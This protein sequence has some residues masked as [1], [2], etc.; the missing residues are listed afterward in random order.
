MINKSRPLSRDRFISRRVYPQ[1]PFP[2]LITGRSPVSLIA[3]GNP[4]SHWRIFGLL[5][6]ATLK[7]SAQPHSSRVF[8]VVMT[9]QSGITRILTGIPGVNPACEIHSPRK[10]IALCTA[11][12][13]ANSVRALMESETLS[14]IITR[15]AAGSSLNLPEPFDAPVCEDSAYDVSLVWTNIQETHRHPTFPTATHTTLYA[16]ADSTPRQ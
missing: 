15:P 8:W 16:S 13:V 2:R 10:N 1:C 6:P 4:S 9:M 11:R 5:I 7:P 12:L 3:P 14:A